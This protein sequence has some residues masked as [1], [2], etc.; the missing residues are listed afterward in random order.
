MS[1][2]WLQ[3]VVYSMESHIYYK[4]KLLN[5]HKTVANTATNNNHMNLQQALLLQGETLKYVRVQCHIS[6][7]IE[8][9]EKPNAFPETFTEGA[10]TQGRNSMF[11]L[12]QDK[13]GSCMST[14]VPPANL[15]LVS[16]YYVLYHCLL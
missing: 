15:Q 10:R 5:T 7:Q 1:D 2:Q 14:P 4:H 11:W 12:H 3:M 16:L 6:F 8:A 9:G 13:G